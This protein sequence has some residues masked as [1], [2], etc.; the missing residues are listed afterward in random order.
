MYNEIFGVSQITAATITVVDPTIAT[1]TPLVVTPG[2]VNTTAGAG[3]EPYEGL[4]V[5]INDNGVAGSL[6]I[7]N[8]QPD[9]GPFFEFV[10]SGN[11]RIDDFVFTRY[12]TPATCMP[13][14]CPYPPAGFLNGRTFTKIVGVLGYSFSN[15]K[16]YPRL[17]ADLQ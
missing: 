5:E 2:Q 15:R 12:G 7:T 16:L 6:A 3:A 14:P 9:T 1:M 10:V 4:L 17:A 8:D 11:L 13:A